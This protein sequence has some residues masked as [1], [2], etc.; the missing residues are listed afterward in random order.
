MTALN[1]ARR[2]PL[3]LLTFAVW[4]AATLSGMRWASDGT[5]KPLV[6]TVMHGISWNL[7]M[8]IAVPALATLDFRWRDLRFV[9]PNQ[10]NL[11]KLVWFPV[12]YLVV[13]FGLCLIPGPPS[14]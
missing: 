14:R 3:A 7:V 6:E 5:K 1:D 4:L 11:L 10:A 8:A 12:L 13:F 2:L 9:A